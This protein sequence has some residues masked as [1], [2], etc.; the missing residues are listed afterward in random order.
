MALRATN[1]IS[2]YLRDNLAI[3]PTPRIVPISG[4]DAIANFM[5]PGQISIT[6]SSPLPEAHL[7][8]NYSVS[9]AAMTCGS[10]GSWSASGLPS[11]LE[12]SPSGML[13]GYPEMFGSNHFTVR[14][15]ADAGG[16]ATN[17]FSLVIRAAPVLLMPLKDSEGQ[18]SFLLSGI[19]GQTYAIQKTTNLA[20]TAWSVL[21]VTNA[22]ADLFPLVDPTATNGDAFYRAI[23]IPPD[24]PDAE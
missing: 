8:E 11:G 5:S 10:G 6:T 20:S 22:P 4:A 13:W 24:Q 23:F 7:N 17:G 3:V 16:Y 18:F 19:A 12:L 21:Y 9:F 2:G 14:V 15:D 1:Y